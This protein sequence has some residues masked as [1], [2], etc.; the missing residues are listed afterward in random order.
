[1][2]N[3]ELVYLKKQLSLEKQKITKLNELLNHTDV[4]EYLK[5]KGLE[6][7]KLEI[8][9]WR[10]IREILSNY[11]I[12]NTNNIYVL[13]G[14]FLTDCSIRYQETDYYI[15]RVNLMDKEA[16]YRIYKNIEDQTIKKAYLKK[17]CFKP[18]TVLTSNF[19]KENIVFI[20][21]NSS[22]NC[23]Y[24]EIRKY[25]FEQSLYKGQ[26]KAKQLLLK[27]YNSI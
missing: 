5:L 14:S 22:I 4:I 16:E 21:E 24:E 27:K 18:S 12:T 25:F 8:D 7:N 1:M 26:T 10:L 11:K 15:R 6:Y 17:D 23:F 19:E 3:K 20:P 13:I 9:D 2:T